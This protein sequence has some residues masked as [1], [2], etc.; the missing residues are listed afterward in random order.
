MRRLCIMTAA[1]HLRLGAS[2]S[3]AMTSYG[4]LHGTQP[5]MNA[6]GYLDSG[7]D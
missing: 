2:V 5:E 6:L 4:N 1:L 7:R 3:N